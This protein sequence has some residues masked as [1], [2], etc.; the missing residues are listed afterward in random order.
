MFR[1]IPD[2]ISSINH[3]LNNLKGRDLGNSDTVV[4]K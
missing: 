3:N 1:M 4:V 2:S